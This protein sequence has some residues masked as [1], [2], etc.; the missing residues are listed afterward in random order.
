MYT[1]KVEEDVSGDL[2]ITLPDDLMEEMGWDEGTL[3]EWIIDE[4]A[5]I[6][7]LRELKEE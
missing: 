6:Y 5:E 7:E 3:L 1:S 4:E 2:Y